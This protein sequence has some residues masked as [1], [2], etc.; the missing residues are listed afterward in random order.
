MVSFETESDRAKSLEQK[1]REYAAAISLDS[2]SP[3]PLHYQLFRVLRLFAQK[4]HLTTDDR[5]PPEE[6][7]ARVF[8]VSRP[9]ATRAIHG[10]VDQQQLTR[11]P[12]RGSFFRSK[13]RLDLTLLANSLSVLEAVRPP[14]RLETKVITQT[15]TGSIPQD[16]QDLGLTAGSAAVYLRRLRSIDGQPVMVC[17]SYL[18]AELFPGLQNEELVRGSL[19]ATLASCHGTQIVRSDRVIEVTELA[20]R[21]IMELLNIPILSPVFL[22]TGLSYDRSDRICEIIVSH[23]VDEARFSSRV[24]THSGPES[25][26]FSAEPQTKGDA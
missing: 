24:E 14:H 6:L 21:D 3:I 4:H 26:A 11:T 17:D 10:F 5:L 19:Y 13:Q 22:L 16:V 1:L 20:D 15:L 25:D 8:G 12:G 18:P 7:V 9:T 23:I 2:T